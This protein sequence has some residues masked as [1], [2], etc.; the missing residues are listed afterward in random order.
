MRPIF[1]VTTR[2]CGAASTS[3]HILSDSSLRRILGF[4][5]LLPST[6]ASPEAHRFYLNGIDIVSI[7]S[8]N[9]T[10]DSLHGPGHVLGNVY[11][12]PWETSGE[13]PE[14]ACGTARLR[15]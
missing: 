14:F 10:E 7:D 5:L 2:R 12:E 1:Q 13:F 8:S 3:K 6:M 11:Y 15:G 4:R 9:M